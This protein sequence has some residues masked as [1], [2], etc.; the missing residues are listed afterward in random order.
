MV[1]SALLK[2]S[3]LFGQRTLAVQTSPLS[4]GVSLHGERGLSVT[5]SGL[6]GTRQGGRARRC[7]CWP[8]V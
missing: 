5:A 8:G 7:G 6:G 2:M 1:G 4:P 3:R